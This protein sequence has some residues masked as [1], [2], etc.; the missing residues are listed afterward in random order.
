MQMYTRLAALG[1]DPE[2][3]KLFERLAAMERGHKTRLEDIYTVHLALDPF[4]AAGRQ[5]GRIGAA[6]LAGEGG[7]IVARSEDTDRH[8]ALDRVI[9]YGLRTSLNFSRTFAIST[10]RITSE[11]ARRCL[12]ANIPA[13]IT[14]GA[15][16]V[17][18]VE[19]AGKTGLCIVGSAG[20]QNRNRHD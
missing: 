4:I 7:R 16:T 11:M 17:L 6:A 20:K 3:R 14:T 19:I 9:G 1:D 5:A 13:I 10:G 18:A 8:N 15:P 2:Q 12:V